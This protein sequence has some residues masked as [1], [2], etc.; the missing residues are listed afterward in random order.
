[1]LGVGRPGSRMLSRRLRVFSKCPCAPSAS[2]FSLVKWA[3]CLGGV[4]GT[5][6]AG[7]PDLHPRS[8]NPQDRRASGFA[9]PTGHFK[10]SSVPYRKSEA[11][12]PGRHLLW[13]LCG[14]YNLVLPDRAASLVNIDGGL[15]EERENKGRFIY[16]RKRNQQEKKNLQA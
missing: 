1:M 2:V 11:Q 13:F 7:I 4:P 10:G 3:C 15:R 9:L 16:D 14:F 12:A 8:R 5:C 6:R